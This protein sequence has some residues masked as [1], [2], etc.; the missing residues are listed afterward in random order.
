MND[1]DDMDLV[2]DL[3]E[4]RL[5]IAILNASKIG[6]EDAIHVTDEAVKMYVGRRANDL[7]ERLTETPA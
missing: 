7:L 5:R 2:Y 1:D 3:N 6:F 4:M